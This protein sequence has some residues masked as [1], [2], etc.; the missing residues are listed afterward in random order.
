MWVMTAPGKFEYKKSG[1]SNNELVAQYILLGADLRELK[2]SW[3]TERAEQLLN[4]IIKYQ[5][6]FEHEL[7]R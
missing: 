1:V 5:A 6:D 3:G 2:E 7:R 4:D